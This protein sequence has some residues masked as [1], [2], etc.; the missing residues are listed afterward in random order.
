MTCAHCHS[1]LPANALYCPQCGRKQRSMPR[2]RRHRPRARCEGSIVKLSGKRRLPYWARGPAEY[3]G[4]TVTRPSLGC[5]ANYAEAAEALGKSKYAPQATPTEIVTLSTMY[6]RFIGS[7]Y[8]DTLSASAQSSHRTAWK[9]LSSCANTPIHMVN[10]ETFQKPIDELAHKGLKR[11]TLA[12]I[13]NLSSLLCKEAMGLGLMTVNY[14]QL[15]QLPRE[16]KSSILPFTSSEL[17]LIWEKADAGDKR[18]MAV[19]LLCYTGMRPGEMLGLRIEVHLHKADSY[20]YFFTGSKTEAGRDRI[21]PI[22]SIIFQIV[23]ALIDNRTEGPLIAAQKGGHYRPDNWRPRCFNTL[24]AELEIN[25]RVPYSGRH[26]YADLQKRRHVAPEIMMEVM[27]HEDYAVTVEHYQTT[28]D[29]DI[30]R[31]CSAIDGLERPK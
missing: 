12:K 1:A 4:N 20:W 31:I 11:E 14:G 27:G 13:R 17:K 24:M 15:V 8:Y 23:L 10:K 9:H 6:D 2:P 25:N 26:T 16:D 22:P 28:T 19:L 18:A 5:Y 3:D 29:E 30:S 7:H 21:I